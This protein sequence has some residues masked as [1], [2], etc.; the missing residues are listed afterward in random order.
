MSAQNAVA[1]LSPDVSSGSAK[2]EPAPSARPETKPNVII[3]YFTIAFTFLMSGSQ[4]LYQTNFLLCLWFLLKG[5]PRA[6]SHPGL[7]ISR[8]PFG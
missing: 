4:G 8:Y 3:K 6:I 1:T 2:T 7:L 5:Q